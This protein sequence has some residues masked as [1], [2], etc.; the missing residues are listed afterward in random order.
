MYEYRGETRALV[1]QN[2]KRG[3]RFSRFFAVLAGL[4]FLS[5]S[6]LSLILPLAGIFTGACPGP[7]F[8]FSGL[9]GTKVFF[10]LADDESRLA[11]E[12]DVALRWLLGA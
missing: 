11:W 6:S 7:R 10:L 5:A 8:R 1:R 2:P 4:N 3:A 9:R 12:V